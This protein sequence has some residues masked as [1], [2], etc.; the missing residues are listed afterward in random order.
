MR[1]SAF[2]SFDPYLFENLN[3]FKRICCKDITD[4]NNYMNR[5]NI[6]N[7]GARPSHV[8]AMRQT[9]CLGHED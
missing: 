7:I 1:L 3:S 2:V 6:E 5:V 8:G 9:D 4:K